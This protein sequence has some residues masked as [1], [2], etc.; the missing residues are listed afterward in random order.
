MLHLFKPRRTLKWTRWKAARDYR[1]PVGTTAVAAIALMVFIVYVTID[2]YGQ[3]VAAFSR[4][5]SLSPYLRHYAVAFLL[6]AVGISLAANFRR[7][8]ARSRRNGGNGLRLGQG[9]L[10]R[11]AFE[12]WVAGL[13][14]GSFRGELVLIAC[15]FA[16]LALLLFVLVFPIL[17]LAYTVATA[18]A[19]TALIR[20]Y[21]DVS[22]WAQTFLLVVLGLFTYAVFGRIP[23]L[24]ATLVVVLRR[25]S[26]RISDVYEH[27][28]RGMFEKTAAP[29]EPGHDPDAAARDSRQRRRRTLLFRSE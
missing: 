9:P 26:I 28:S 6:L 12:L 11:T 19:V 17:L 8:V 5:I 29:P 24:E 20:Q 25:W 4:A 2:T 3:H 15:W 16:R 1:N 10:G 21:V 7:P 23:R 27:L 18:V 14:P 22:L 13:T